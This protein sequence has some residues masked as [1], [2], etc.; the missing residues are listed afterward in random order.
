MGLTVLPAE[1][2][3]RL[4]GAAFTYRE[5]GRTAGGLPDGY[6]HLTRR[7]LIGHG[8]QLFTTAGDAVWRWQVQVRAGLRVSVSAPAAIP[9][10]VVV[11][12]LGVG[13]VRVEAPCRVV[14][15]VDE[16]RRRGFAYGTLP[17]HPESGEEAFVVEHHDDD[18]VSFTVTAFSRPAT[19]LARI[20]GPLGRIAQRR[21]TAR[22]LRSVS[23]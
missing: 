5:V 18:A 4:A 11:L 7:V 15:A 8:H 23:A 13:P 1:E 21:I 12:G 9:G 22:Y 10:T 2:L 6:R 20:A 17:G 16:P 14:Y 19:R 3:D